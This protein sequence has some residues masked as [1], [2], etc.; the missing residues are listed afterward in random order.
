YQKAVEAGE[1]V[2]VGVNQ[3]VM[4]DEKIEIPVLK[5]DE[6]V[7]REQIESLRQLRQARDNDKVART[8]DDLRQAAERDDNLMPSFIEC[9]RVYATLG[10]IVDVLRGIYGEYEEPPMI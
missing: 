1:R 7:E 6:T 10:E 8:L 9:A 3:F 5:I 2:I 4:D